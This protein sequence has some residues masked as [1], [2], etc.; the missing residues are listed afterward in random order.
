MNRDRIIEALAAIEVTLGGSKPVRWLDEG[1]V[2]KI[3]TPTVEAL[4][5]EARA[6]D[7]AHIAGLEAAMERVRSIR[8]FGLS[9][10]IYREDID[11]A[12]GGDA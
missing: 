12:L 1:T 7:A 9:G 5:A 10:A 8:G 4:I 6:A 3:L 2:D 11:E